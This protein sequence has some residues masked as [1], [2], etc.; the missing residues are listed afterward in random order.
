MSEIIDNPPPIKPLE[1]IEEPGD[2]HIE[3]V[4][5]LIKDSVNFVESAARQVDT[6]NGVLIGIYFHAI[7]YNG[8]KQTN[9]SYEWKVL[10]FLPIVFWLISLLVSF[11]VHSPR[12]KKELSYASEE[13]ATQHFNHFLDRKFCSYKLS[14]GFFIIGLI[15]LAVVLVHFLF[16]LPVAENIK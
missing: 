11:L 13:I 8:I 6:I 9:I 12:G 2:L 10:Y 16:F 1:I 4:K 15:L 7:T 14:F 5:T 3:A